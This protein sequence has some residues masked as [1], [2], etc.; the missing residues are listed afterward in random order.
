M[1]AKNPLDQFVELFEKQRK[2]IEN[3]IPEQLLESFQRVFDKLSN[4]HFPPKG[5]EGFEKISIGDFFKPELGVN[6]YR[7]NLIDSKKNIGCGIENINSI[8]IIL[9]NDVLVSIILP[10]GMKELPHGLEISS[11]D[12]MNARD[13]E[14]G[15]LTSLKCQSEPE[16]LLNLLFAP[17][18][19][20]IYVEPNVQIEVPLQ[21]ICYSGSNFPLLCN[22]K[23]FIELSENSSLDILSCDHSIENDTVAPVV[24][25]SITKLI[26]HESSRLC[27][28]DMEETNEGNKRISNL[29]V[30]QYKNSQLE[31]TGVTLR[32]GITRNNIN[33]ACKESN[34]RTML[35]GLVIA[36]SSSH[37]DYYTK[38]NHTADN[39]WSD[40]LFKYAL[41]DSA[42]G[43]FGG[44]ITVEKGARFN[45][46]F[47]NNKNI[48]ISED[49]RMFSKPQLLIYNDDVKC[50][51]GATTGQLDA[52]ALYYMQTRGI[53]KQE[54]ESMLLQAFMNDLVQRLNFP[55]LK[56]RLMH[57]VEKRLKGEDAFCGTCKLY[58]ND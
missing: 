23:I 42:S 22:R 30:D 25:N 7:R 11:F 57:L 38:L 58:G 21:I 35:N 32:N 40:Q 16:I 46:A 37:A 49:A 15:Y 5:S 51:H 9:H 20:S 14:I 26:L 29:F 8:R 39:G 3:Q 54:A 31:M 24:V 12:A 50:S 41:F 2:E 27:Y 1:D 52:R 28:V 4:S 56:E 53:S 6:F 47:Q 19:I 17:N 44:V 33:I 48:I 43:S 13:K 34:T 36:K 18:G 55:A 10:K 45:E